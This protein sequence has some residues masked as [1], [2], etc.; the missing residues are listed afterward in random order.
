MTF[1]VCCLHVLIIL[2]CFKK[3][4]YSRV[5]KREKKENNN[6]NNSKIAKLYIL[7]LSFLKISTFSYDQDLCGLSTVYS[8]SLPTT[9]PEDADDFCFWYLFCFTFIDIYI[10]CFFVL[11][12]V[13][14]VW[15]YHPPRFLFNLE[16]NYHNIH[17]SRSKRLSRVGSGQQRLLQ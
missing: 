17:Q 1:I 6:N 11:C 16:Y 13:N 2:V 7:N 10:F 5:K 14:I 15:N 3:K 4:S 8:K 9:T 12:Y